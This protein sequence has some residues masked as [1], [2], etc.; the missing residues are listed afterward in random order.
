[1]CV[2]KVSASIGE[3][4]LRPW[5]SDEPRTHRLTRRHTRENRRTNTG[6]LADRCSHMLWHDEVSLP[7]ALTIIDFP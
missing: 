1:V 2:V 3:Q 6:R 4:S 5:G 7:L